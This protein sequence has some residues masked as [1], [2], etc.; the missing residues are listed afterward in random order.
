MAEALFWMAGVAISYGAWRFLQIRGRIKPR[1]RLFFVAS[2]NTAEMVATIA[3][4]LTDHTADEFEI[5]S[6]DPENNGLVL[7]DVRTPLYWYPIRLFDLGGG[8]AL[9]R[10]GVTAVWPLLRPD[11][12]ER[13][14]SLLKSILLHK[15]TVATR[16]EVLVW[17]HRKLRSVQSV[18]DA[19]A[20]RVVPRRT[21]HVRRDLQSGLTAKSPR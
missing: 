16:P 19:D 18:V 20:H 14:H 15:G 5:S 11:N 1:R 10:V 6:V 12:H 7:R 3:A 21:L 17:P 4:G 2:G 13:C 8:Q 9:V